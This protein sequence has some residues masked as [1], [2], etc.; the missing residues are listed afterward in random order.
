LWIPALARAIAIRT[1]DREFT[2]PFPIRR[3]SP[4]VHSLD[5]LPGVFVVAATVALFFGLSLGVIPV[6]TVATYT[7]RSIWTAAWFHALHNV[8]SQ[9]IV[10]RTLGAGDELMLG[11]SGIFP[12]AAYLFAAAAVLLTLKLRWRDF[13]ARYVDGA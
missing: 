13:A 8:F 3:L 12:V 9:A 6:W 2:A 4:A 11:E 7:T 5:W 10:P 1:V